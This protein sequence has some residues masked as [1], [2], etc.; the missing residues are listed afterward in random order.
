MKYR[1]VISPDQIQATQVTLTKA[2]IHYLQR[3]LRLRTG[4]NFIALDGQG[5]AWRAQL[6]A[7]QAQLLDLLSEENELALPVTL[8]IAVP[9]GNGLGEIIRP[10]TELGAQA[11]QPLLTT[12]TLAQPGDNKLQRWRRISAEAAEQSERQWVPPIAMPLSFA[13]FLEQWPAMAAMGLL[14]VARGNAPALG[15]YLKQAPPPESIILATGPEGGWSAEE[16]TLAIDAGLQPISLGKTI[17]R[18][19]TAPTVALAQIAVLVT[20]P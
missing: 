10:C 20:V 5:A 14:C 15:A 11:F 6:Q 16:I 1:L 9:K 17:L 18:A 4:D 19:V 3:V 7:P 8:A 12:R 2:Q 13:D